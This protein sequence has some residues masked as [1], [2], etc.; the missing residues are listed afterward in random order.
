MKK[1]K[2]KYTNFL[3]LSLANVDDMCKGQEGC[4]TGNNCLPKYQKV[5]I[6][7]KVADVVKLAS[8]QTAQ[9][10]LK[11]YKRALEYVTWCEKYE[12]DASGLCIALCALTGLSYADSPR[13]DFLFPE[14]GKFIS[15]NTP[16]RFRHLLDEGWSPTNKWR[17]RVLKSCI[18]I[19]KKEILKNKKQ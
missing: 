2:K 18:R 17:I 6:N 5:R 1:N 4:I 7:D 15:Y 13:T 14:F 10:R 8:I 9:K 3:H 12:K 16:T 19:C 11:F